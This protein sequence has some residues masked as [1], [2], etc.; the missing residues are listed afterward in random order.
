MLKHYLFIINLLLS[1]VVLGQTKVKGIV[2][3]VEGEPLP[4]ASV[5]FEQSTEDY[6]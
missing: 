2:V 3:D 4:F 6:H 1:F 5:V